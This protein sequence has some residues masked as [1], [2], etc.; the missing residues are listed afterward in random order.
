MEASIRRLGFGQILFVG[1]LSLMIAIRPDVYFGNAGVS[2]F[3]ILR[4]TAALFAITFLVGAL[5]M[6][7]VAGALPA[8]GTRPVRNTLRLSAVLTTG[9]V[10]FP[11]IGDGLIDHIHIAFAVVLFAVESFFAIWLTAR[12][13]RDRASVTL[14]VILIAAALASLLALCCVLHC[15]TQAEIAF[16]LSFNLLLLRLMRRQGDISHTSLLQIGGYTHD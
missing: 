16:Q 3:G 13:G 6:W 7:A 2:Q 10:V 5:S 14:L 8:S 12:S 15:K 9:L 4:S 1:L 11:A